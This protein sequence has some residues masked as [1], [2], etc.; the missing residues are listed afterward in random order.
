[1]LTEKSQR[2]NAQYHSIVY[3]TSKASGKAH[4][5]N[6]ILDGIFND[7]KQTFKILQVILNGHSKSTIQIFFC[8]KTGIFNNK[9]L[10]KMQFLLLKRHFDWHFVIK[11][12]DKRPFPFHK[13]SHYQ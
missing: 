11:F 12:N 3:S 1:M 2:N 13:Q 4:I 7:R 6:G 5:L 8:C 9:I 10:F